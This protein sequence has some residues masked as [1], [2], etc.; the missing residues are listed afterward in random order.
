MKAVLFWLVVFGLVVPVQE[1]LF[2]LGCSSRPRTKYC[3][4]LTVHYFNSFVPIALRT[5]QAAVLDCQSF[6]ACLCG[7]VQM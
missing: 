1:I 4:S 3:F 5:G 6:R 7:H 2:Y